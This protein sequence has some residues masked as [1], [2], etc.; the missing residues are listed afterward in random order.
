MSLIQDWND[1]SIVS[2]NGYTADGS[3]SQVRRQMIL[4]KLVAECDTDA[5]LEVI[6]HF[7]WLIEDRG[8]RMP[9][10]RRIWQEDRLYTIRLFNAKP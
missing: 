1:D 4:S 3:I 7:G 8:H 6:A 5:L 2:R 9:N 10:A